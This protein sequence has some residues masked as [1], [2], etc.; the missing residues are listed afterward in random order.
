[1]YRSSSSR[2]V[3]EL[4]GAKM[5]PANCAVDGARDGSFAHSSRSILAGLIVNQPSSLN[6]FS[7]PKNSGKLN[8]G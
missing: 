4:G 7:T 1:M 8:Q 2:V 5:P 3:S 6:T